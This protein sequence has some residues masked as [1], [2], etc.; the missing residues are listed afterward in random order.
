[1]TEDET[2]VWYE[3]NGT[4]HVLG[5]PP[6]T[7]EAAE[8]APVADVADPVEWVAPA[9]AADADDREVH[10][11]LSDPGIRSESELAEHID[12]IG[13]CRKCPHGCADLFVGGLGLESE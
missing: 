11:T 13:Q 4:R 6:A 3:A 2:L 5:E 8:P 12:L 9:V 7:V 1:M 10:R